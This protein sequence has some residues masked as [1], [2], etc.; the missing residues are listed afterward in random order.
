M[1]PANPGCPSARRPRGFTLIELL[2]VI[3]II[4]ILA[5][6]LLPA[7][8]VVKN[9]ARVAMAKTEMKGLALAIGAYE[10]DNTRY[11]ASAPAR[12]GISDNC[13]DFTFGTGNMSDD[14]STVTFVD[15]KTDGK[16]LSRPQEVQNVG[17]TAPW[18]YSN[19]EVMAAL[20][21]AVSFRDGVATKNSNHEMNPK[22]TKYFQPKESN[23]TKSPGLGEDG[24]FRDPWGNPYII[25]LDM[26]GDEKCRDAVYRLSNVSK[27]SSTSNKG[28][29]GLRQGVPGVADTYEANTPIMIW[30]FRPDGRFDKNQS[31]KAGLNKDNVLSWQ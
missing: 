13:P 7:L 3:A 10:A 21:D 1:N 16:P 6:M 2:V 11:P 8:S 28:L 20:L 14:L 17:Q 27:E 22:G 15:G 23:G 12:K 9:R 31:A 25:T 30:S 18:Q 26:N 4:G 29:F 5:G 24:V 19:A